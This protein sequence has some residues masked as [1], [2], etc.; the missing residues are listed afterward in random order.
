MALL[1]HVYILGEIQMKSLGMLIQIMQE[2][3]IIRDHLICIYNQDCTIS[4]KAILQNPVALSTKA[5]YMA[6]TE[7]S[8]KA[9][10]LRE[11]FGEINED[12][13]MFIIYCDSQSAISF[14]G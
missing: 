6:S 14:K 5:E 9:I 12:L 2:I 4:W 11:L 7:A 3:L 13:H 10:Q 8:K 1:M